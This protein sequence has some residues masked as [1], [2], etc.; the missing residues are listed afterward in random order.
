MPH[1]VGALLVDGE[2]RQWRHAA[3]VAPRHAIV[4]HG[5]LGVAGSEYQALS[6]V[7]G[8]L[9]ADSTVAERRVE[10]KV[11]R[12]ARVTH[13][14]VTTTAVDMEV[15]PGAR[16]EGTFTEALPRAEPGRVVG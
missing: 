4:E 12:S 6:W 5:F 3:F 14:S 13:G 11:E 7:E 8:T 9:F 2:T 16:V 15:C 1:Q 10:A